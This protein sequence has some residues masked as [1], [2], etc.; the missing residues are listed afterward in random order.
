[1]LRGLALQGR[2]GQRAAYAAGQAWPALPRPPSDLEA[3]AGVVDPHT[4]KERQAHAAA[5]DAYEVAFRLAMYE[6][7]VRGQWPASLKPEH[8]A[9]LMDQLQQIDPEK[10]EKAVPA[11]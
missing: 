3:A 6:W 1:V 8:R 7:L 2:L 9:L 11:P 5:R 10:I 4:T